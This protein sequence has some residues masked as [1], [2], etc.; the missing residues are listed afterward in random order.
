MGILSNLS[1]NAENQT[2]GLMQYT[3]QIG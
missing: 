3:L 2:P 1:N